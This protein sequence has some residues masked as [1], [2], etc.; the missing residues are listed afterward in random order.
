MSLWWVAKPSVRYCRGGE[1]RGGEGRGGEGRGG[2]GRGGEGRGGEGR[3][4]EGRG[5]EGR[6]NYKIVLIR[7]QGVPPRYLLSYNYFLLPL[8]HVQM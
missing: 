7:H 5:G 4:G 8:S 1:G 3:G 2:E 6:N